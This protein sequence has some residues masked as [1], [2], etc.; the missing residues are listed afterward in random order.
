MQNDKI[1]DIRSRLRAMLKRGDIA[2][3]RERELRRVLRQVELAGGDPAKQRAAIRRF[4]RLMI[5][6]GD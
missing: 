1:R 2:P 5:G 6:S 4:L 3:G